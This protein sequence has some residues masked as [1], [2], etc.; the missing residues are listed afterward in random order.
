M[1]T[2]RVSW[3]PVQEKPL[4]GV[5]TS[6]TCARVISH[7]LDGILPLQAQ[8][9]SHESPFVCCLFDSVQDAHEPQM[10]PTGNHRDRPLFCGFPSTMARLFVNADK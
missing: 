7:L 6:E 3:E 9:L 8:R 2:A 4:N 1:S 10:T 5:L